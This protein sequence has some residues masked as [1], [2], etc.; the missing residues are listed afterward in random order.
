MK[1]ILLEKVHKLGD[2][3]DTVNVAPGYGRNYLIPQGRAVPA[4]EKNVAKFEARRAEL[5]KV[6]KE[7]LAEAEKRAESMREVNLEITRKALET[8]RLFGSVGVRDIVE[9]LGEKGI[10]V[11]KSE[12]ILSAGSIH[13]IGEYEVELLLHSDVKVTVPVKIISEE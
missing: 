8:G 4:T 12:V 6:A 3:G 9:A 7:K 2:L 13:E 11:E 1:V 5:E 10:P